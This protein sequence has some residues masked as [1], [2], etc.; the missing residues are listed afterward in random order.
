[1]ALARYCG[2]DV[3]HSYRLMHLTLS[4]QLACYFW[5]VVD[6]FKG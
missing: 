1:M 4:L 2:L 5:N 6:P 3:K